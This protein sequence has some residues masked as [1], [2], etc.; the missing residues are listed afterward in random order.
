[1][2]ESPLINTRLKTI[3]AVLIIYFI[4]F[5]FRALEY[6]VIRTDQTFF[7]EAFIHKLIGIGILILAVF[8]FNISLATSASKQARLSLIY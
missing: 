5:A 4:C 3:L 7:G 2:N 1:M 8:I 6:F